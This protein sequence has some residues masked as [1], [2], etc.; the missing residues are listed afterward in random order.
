MV[1]KYEMLCIKIVDKE[2]HFV[3]IEVP[4]QKH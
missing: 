3:F 2:S 4:L 1:T